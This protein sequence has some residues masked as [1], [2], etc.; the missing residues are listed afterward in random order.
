MA[1][2]TYS[3]YP[4]SWATDRAAAGTP[5]SRTGTRRSEQATFRLTCGS[6]QDRRAAHPLVGG[7]GVFDDN[8]ADVLTGSA[9]SDWFFADFGGTGVRDLLSDPGNPEFVEDT[10]P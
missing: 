3:L 6:Y 9:G 7:A 2:C 1:P 5:G 4:D 10:H 8:E